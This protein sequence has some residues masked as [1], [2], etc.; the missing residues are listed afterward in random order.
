[1]KMKQLTIWT[2]I[3]VVFIAVVWGLIALVNNSASPQTAQTSPPP[4]LAKDDQVLGATDKAKAESDSVRVTLIEY[5]D[6]QCPACA[7]SAPLIRQLEKDIGEDLL[8]VY[9]Y[10]PLI[11]IH[12]NAMSSSQAAFA[13]GKQNKFWEMSDLLYENQGK[14]AE[15]ANAKDIFAEYAKKLGLNIDQFTAD[16]NADSTKKFILDQVNS[17]ISIGINATPTFFVNGKKI[18]SPRSYNAFKQIIQNTLSQ[19]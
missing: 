16:F 15:S 9:R 5:A 10:F 17:G 14:W 6:F 8:I 13:A 7:N 19:K 3:G 12:K 1:M 2:G 4:P 18:E 11:S